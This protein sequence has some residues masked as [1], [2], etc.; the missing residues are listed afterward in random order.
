MHSI[1]ISLALTFALT[2]SVQAAKTVCRDAKT[3]Q[4][5]SAAYAKHYPGLTVCEPVKKK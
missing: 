3:G 2:T 1:L 4:Y 5:V